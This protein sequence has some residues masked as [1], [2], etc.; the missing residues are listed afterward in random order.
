MLDMSIPC[1]CAPAPLR[2]CRSYAGATSILMETSHTAFVMSSP[3]ACHVGRLEDLTLEQ[4]EQL[5]AH[6]L[7]RLHVRVASA[8]AGQPMP[9][10]AAGRMPWQ[11]SR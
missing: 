3:L 5:L 8:A 10:S 4:R 2:C 7:E 1:S 9:G 6:L 11:C